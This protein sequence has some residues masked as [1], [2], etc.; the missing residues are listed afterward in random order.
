ML[1]Q[2]DCALRFIYF[3]QN[4]LNFNCELNFEYTRHST[5]TQTYEMNVI[6]VNEFLSCFLL[7][8]SRTESPLKSTGQ[9]YY[10]L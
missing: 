3:Q 10:V 4:L 9:M 7:D 6:S 8:I 2:C 5:L 1:P